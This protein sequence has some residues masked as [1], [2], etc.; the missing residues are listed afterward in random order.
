M[1]TAVAISLTL[2]I[3]TGLCAGQG[4]F[5]QGSVNGA[6]GGTAMF[7]TNLIPPAQPFI[8]ISWTVGGANIIT[9]TSDDSIGPGY[10]DR[11][12][13]NKTTGSLE[14]R[15]LTLADSGG[16]RVAITTATAETI[17]GSTEL[18][19]YE[20]VSD[21]NITGP[22]NNLFA[23]VSS[24]NLTCE[25]AG[26]ITTI[27]W[28]KEGQPLSAG[29]NI[30]FSEENRKV[31]ISPVK[32]HDSGEYVCK[33]TNPASSATASYRMIVNYGPE[34][35]T[36]LGR[37]IAEVESFTLIYCSVQSVP[38]A[39]FTWLFNGQ[40]TG[41]HEAGYIIRSVSYNN[42]GDYRCDARND[43]TGNVISVDHSLSVKDKTPPPLSPEG[44][45][46]IAVA[47]MLVVVAVALGLYFGLTHQRN[48]STNTTETGSSHAPDTNHGPGTSLAPDTSHG[49]GAKGGRVYEN[50]GPPL[51]PPRGS[52]IYNRS[53]K[54]WLWIHPSSFTP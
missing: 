31:S 51:P 10:G 36:I 7:I 16:Y 14:L 45:A 44:A 39:T 46:G 5:P 40:Q 13:L 26:N 54:C 19:V 29:G 34:S 48:N 23:D 42:S 41:V 38:P 17:N 4:L 50:L 21:A 11:I 35:M 25:A 1:E 9:S 18:V 47:V 37:H 52:N 3:L 53:I 6:E 22:S 49:P 15:N 28:T 2:F 8:I 43:L 33:L 30:L 12:T 32:R 27:Q 20:N 24:A